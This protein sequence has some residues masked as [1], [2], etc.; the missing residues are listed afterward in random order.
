MRKFIPMKG[1]RLNPLCPVDMSKLIFPLYASPKIDG[2]RAV[3]REGCVKSYKLIDLP[4]RY[5]QSRFRNIEGL[6]GE[7]II[8]QP[9]LKNLFR[10][11][12]SAVMTEE[13][14]PDILFRAF[15]C[16]QKPES[17]FEERLEHIELALDFAQSQF[18][19]PVKQKKIKS[20]DDFLQYE[21]DQVSK[22]WEGVMVRSP[23]GLYKFGR[24][25]VR[26]QY[27]L[28]ITRRISE[29][30]K[31]VGYEERMKNDNKLQTNNHGHAKRSSHKANKVGHGDLGALW[32]EN[33]KYP[34]PFKVG[35]GF[36]AKDRKE[37]WDNRK[38]YMGAIVKYEF[39]PTGDYDVPRNASFQGFRDP[40]D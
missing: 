13:G 9:T 35:T 30:G 21:H 38:K 10:N 8:N 2:V 4:N 37:I 6:D 5:T 31:V 20:L 34:K 3:I 7:L 23:S 26:E 18:A 17:S 14:S 32:V 36:D 15:D 24:S 12:N 40:R 19:A 28:K 11:T 25:T 29:E 27:M 33:P 16:F 1:E 39:A 22:G